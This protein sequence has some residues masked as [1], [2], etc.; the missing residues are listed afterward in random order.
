M[1]LGSFTVR[2][3]LP[4]R[5]GI[6]C[7]GFFGAG[8]D[9]PL[10]SDLV[11]GSWED[12]DG[13][14]VIGDTTGM[15]AGQ[16]TTIAPSSRTAQLLI[17]ADSVTLTSGA[18]TSAVVASVTAPDSMGLQAFTLSVEPARARSVDLITEAM[19]EAFPHAGDRALEV[20]SM[21]A[22]SMEVVVDAIADPL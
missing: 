2:P 7:R 22:V 3:S 21:E 6:Q 13:A 9:S 10:A 14:G 5:A 15:A 11:S 12:L 1:I 16:C 4:T 20:A 18:V 19:F 17:T 8:S